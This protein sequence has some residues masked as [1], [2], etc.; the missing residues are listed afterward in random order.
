MVRKIVEEHLAT[1]G[2][3]ENE[4]SNNTGKESPDPNEKV[5]LSKIDEV[6]YLLREINKNIQELQRELSRTSVPIRTERL[7]QIVSVRNSSVELPSFVENNPWLEV[8]SLR[9]T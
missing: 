7:K 6:I 8:L 1:L 3:L 5:Y 9:K 4:K 2:I